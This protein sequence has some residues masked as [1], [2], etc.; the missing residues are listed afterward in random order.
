MKK[1]AVTNPGAEVLSRLV[2]SVK[3]VSGLPECKN[4]FKKMHG[5]LVRRI[6]LLSPLFEELRDGN[7]GLSQEEIKGFE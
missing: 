3:E 5:N 1:M 6:K 4:F 7:E 2:A